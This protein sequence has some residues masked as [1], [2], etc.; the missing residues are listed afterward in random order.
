MPNLTFVLPHGLYWAGLVLFPLFAMWIAG[1]QRRLGLRH[2]TSTAIAYFLLLTGGFIG[3]HRFYLKS[4]L[5]LIFIPLF[6][7]VLYGNIEVRSA[8]DA[9]SAARSNEM[10]AEFDQERAEM[11]VDRNTPGAQQALDKA[12]AAYQN[13]RKE[14][15]LANDSLAGWRQFSASL[16]TLIALLMIVDAFRIPALTRRCARTEQTQ[17]RTTY[18]ASSLSIEPQKRKQPTR[19]IHSRFTDSIDKLNGFLGEYVSYWSVVA[20]FVYYY[21][22]L[23]RYIFNSPTNWAHESMFLMFGMQYLL[24]G[25]YALREGAHVRVDVIYA[26]FSDRAKALTDVIT[27]VFFFIFVLTLLGTGW[28][29]FQDAFHAGEVSFTEWG[30]QYWPVK[31]AIPLGALLLLAQGLAR[32]TKDVLV[33]TG[34]EH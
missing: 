3:L 18:D 14:F 27:S 28:I 22:V 1:R 25:A 24:A 15:E 13:A 26:H 19:G 2:D 10:I 12:Q 4:I 6:L 7:A 30:I 33:L 20:V 31:F 34:A 21:E 32:L 8:L 5:G 16:A 23:A 11:A 29:F 9:L 17:Q